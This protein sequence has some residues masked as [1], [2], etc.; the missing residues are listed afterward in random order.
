MLV[1]GVQSIEGFA[2]SDAPGSSGGTIFAHRYNSAFLVESGRVPTATTRSSSR[3][4]AGHP[5]SL[6]V[7]SPPRPDRR[8][9][10]GGMKFDLTS[11]SAY[12]G[13]PLTIRRAESE[14]SWTRLGAMFIRF[15]TPICF[16]ATKPAHC[17]A[18][19]RAAL[20]DCISRS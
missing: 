4:S 13:L 2:L 11:G 17:R 7:G 10:A 20:A 6:G 15:I 19:V 18:L 1:V 5:L 14:L 16:E 12:T 9:G 8:A 3:P